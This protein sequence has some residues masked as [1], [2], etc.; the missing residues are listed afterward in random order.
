M[1]ALK[2]LEQHG[3]VHLKACVDANLILSI[4]D[5]LGRLFSRPSDYSGDIENHPLIGSIRMDVMN[6]HPQFLP[7]M[8][9]PRI[10][11]TLRM[12]L[13]EDFQYLPETAAHR[14]GY[15]GWHKDTTSQERAGHVFHKA[16]GYRMVQVAIYFQAN[17][18]YGGGLDVRP[19]SHKEPDQFLDAMDKTFFDKLRT[20]ARRYNLLPAIFGR[21]LEGVSLASR[22]GDVV[23]FDLRLDHKATWPSRKGPI[24]EDRQKYALFFVASRRSPQVDDYVRFIAGRPDY[25]YLQ[26]YQV[27]HSLRAAAVSA[28]IE[29]AGLTK[30]QEPARPSGAR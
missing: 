20:K 27:S 9:H 7:L 12:L 23:I 10:L 2:Q 26:N 19:G 5:E 3:F 21:R 16:P 8:F 17:G 29:L 25:V 6:R 14:G 28:G 11:E 1:E 30:P 4:R 13:G 24:P 22:P 18:E 15:G